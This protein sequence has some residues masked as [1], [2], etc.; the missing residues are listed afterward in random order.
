VS[1]VFTFPH[2]TMR[3]TMNLFHRIQR[4]H[5]PSASASRARRQ[6]RQRPGL[7]SLE[8]RQ[9]LSVNTNSFQ[10]NSTQGIADH[11]SDTASS[12]SGIRVVV[13]E[14]V[15]RFNSK[16]H[17]IYAQMYNQDGSRRGGQITVEANNL[18]QTN[19]RVAMRSDGAFVVVWEENSSD[20]DGNTQS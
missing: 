18:F 1:G 15:Y 20:I 10:V 2:Y 16:D 19:P 4:T 14:D 9:L 5:Q 11:N 7:E 6:R 13:W 12:S 8:G 17:D 3:I